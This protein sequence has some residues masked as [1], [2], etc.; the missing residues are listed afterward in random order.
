MRKKNLSEAKNVQNFT[1]V[2]CCVTALYAKVKANGFTDNFSRILSAMA[3]AIV[4]KVEFNFEVLLYMYITILVCL[5][6]GS[7][8]RSAI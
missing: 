2:L 6:A 8:S 3:L 4:P 1:L 5:S 7:C